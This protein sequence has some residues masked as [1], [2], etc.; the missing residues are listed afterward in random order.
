MVKHQRGREELLALLDQHLGFLSRSGQAY[1][2]GAEDE[3]IRL[4]V[5]LRVLLHDTD[6]SHSLLG[7]LGIKDKVDFVDT[8]MPPPPPGVIQLH[9]GIVMMGGTLG[10]PSAN[11]RYV[12]FLGNLPPDRLGRTAPFEAWWKEPVVE[13]REGR[14]VTRRAMVL[15]VANKE[16]A[17]VDPQLNGVYA[18]LTKKNSLGWTYPDEAGID[19]PLQGNIGHAT[20]RQVTWEVLQSL[21]TDELDRAGAPLGNPEKA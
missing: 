10:G 15:A 5:S 9:S 8:T 1:D 4:A 6:K 19:R 12:P 3:A 13:D 2:E 21:T 7:Q 16:G 20:V 18:A 11:T 14:P 17:H